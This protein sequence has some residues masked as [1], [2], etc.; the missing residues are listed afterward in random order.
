MP[1]ISQQQVPDFVSQNGA[2][3]LAP[4]TAPP[5]LEFLRPVLEYRRNRREG[6]PD[7]RVTHAFA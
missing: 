7:Q 3:D 5:A 6:M 2:E 4:R 1:V